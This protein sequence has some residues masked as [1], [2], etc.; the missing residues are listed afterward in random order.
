MPVRANEIL[1][2][3]RDSLLLI[4]LQTLFVVFVALILF[5]RLYLSHKLL[6]ASCDDMETGEQRL[7][8]CP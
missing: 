7:D 5:Q 3:V 4:I 8:Y 6:Q 2:T 1:S